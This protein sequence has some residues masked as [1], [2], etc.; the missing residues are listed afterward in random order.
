MLWLAPLILLPLAILRTFRLDHPRRPFFSYHDLLS[1]GRLGLR[2]PNHNLLPLML[3]NVH[4]HHEQVLVELHLG[5]LYKFQSS[6]IYGGLN[7]SIEDIAIVSSLRIR[8]MPFTIC[9]L[10]ELFRQRYD[11]TTWQFN[12]LFLLQVV[13]D[14]ITLSNVKCV[15]YFIL[16]ALRGRL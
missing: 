14:P 4:I 3:N 9:M 10:F 1:L 13:K 7:L 12:L 15:A 16:S 6:F 11:V 8:I 2:W 5:T